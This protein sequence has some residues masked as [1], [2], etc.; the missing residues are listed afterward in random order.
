[1]HG[2]GVFTA[3]HTDS[4]SL[5]HRDTWLAAVKNE[6]DSPKSQSLRTSSELI[7]RFSGLISGRKTRH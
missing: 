2:L 5:Q 7:R 4:K 3:L 1:M 6:E